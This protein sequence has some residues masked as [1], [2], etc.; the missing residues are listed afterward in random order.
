MFLFSDGFSAL[1]APLDILSK[2]KH[3]HNDNHS[4]QTKINKTTQEKNLSLSTKRVSQTYRC[5]KVL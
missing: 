4:T 1:K 2:G 5:F 3:V